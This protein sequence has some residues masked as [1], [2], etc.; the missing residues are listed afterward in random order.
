[1][2]V[3]PRHVDADQRRRLVAEAL[4]RVVLRDGLDR[5]TVRNVAREAGLSLG[6]ISHWFENQQAVQLH[7]LRLLEQR[8][9][10]RLARVS[11]EGPARE[12]VERVLWATLPLTRELREEAQVYYAFMERARVT[13]AFRA[14]AAE[15]NAEVMAFGRQGI[16]LLGRHGQIDPGRDLDAVAAEF[17][18][19]TEGLSFQSAMWP[20]QLPARRVRAILRR[21]LDSLAGPPTPG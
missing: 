14:I 2:K 7:A 21:W 9:E 18:A 4:W 6:A 17:H 15:I 10:A 20:E 11:F 12:V 16:E 3:V 8:S 5:A 19:L 1:M 13:P